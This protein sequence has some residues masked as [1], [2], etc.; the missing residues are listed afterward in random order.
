M[1]IL[2]RALAALALL[3]AL[4]V[5]AVAQDLT[6]AQQ[7]ALTERVESF[8]TAM[9]EN[10]MQTVMG[11]VPPKVLE[12][13]AAQSNLSVDD[14]LAAMQAQMDEIMGKVE[15]VSFGM[16]LD[17]VEYTTFDSGIVYGMIPTETVIDLGADAG[18]KM[19]ATSQTL[20]LLDGDTWYLVRIDDPAQVAIIKE[21]YPD[22]ADV[23]FPAGTV[24]P[25]TE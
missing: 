2:N 11:V 6:E 15:I 20:G 12:K 19:K 17:G 25:V 13:I 21:I 14:L 9:R 18:G 4:A 7:T 16:E 23:E 24:E 10:D 8:D 5:P 22:F 3:V 1:T